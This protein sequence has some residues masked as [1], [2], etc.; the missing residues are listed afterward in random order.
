ME[1]DNH[2]IITN[3]IREPRM[4]VGRFTLYEYDENSIWIQRDDGEG[5]QASN[6]DFAEMLNQFWREKF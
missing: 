2:P 4:E 1:Q 3:K 6:D 5:M